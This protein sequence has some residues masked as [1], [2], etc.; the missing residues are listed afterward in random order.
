LE[1][2]H[3]LERIFKSRNL[4]IPKSR[5]SCQK[6]RKQG[7]AF[8]APLDVLPAA[9]A[10]EGKRY[11]TEKSISS[12]HSELIDAVASRVIQRS[13]EMPMPGKRH[14]DAA[15]MTLVMISGAFNG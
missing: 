13:K 10:S 11:G 8:D 5:R 7:F 4:L 1:L 6:P 14:I 15:T 3:E 12:T 2:N 9:L